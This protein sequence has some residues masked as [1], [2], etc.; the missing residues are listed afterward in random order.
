MEELYIC[1]RP[2][3]LPPREVIVG[4]TLQYMEVGLNISTNLTSSMLEKLLMAFAEV[5][6][7]PVPVLLPP[8]IQ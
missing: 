2:A 8:I 5:D 3:T 7:G 6:L 1:T 4:V